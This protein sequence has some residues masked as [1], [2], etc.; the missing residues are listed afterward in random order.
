MACDD[1]NQCTFNDVCNSSSS[2][3]GTLALGTLCDDGN[4]CTFD[5]VCTNYYGCVGSRADDGTPCYRGNP[6]SPADYC[7]DGQCYDGPFRDCD[8]RDRCDGIDYCDFDSGECVPYPVPLCD[9]HNECTG[10]TCDPIAGCVFTPIDAPCDDGDAC[11]VGDRCVNRACLWGPVDDCDDANPC[12]DDSCDVA[13]G[14]LH[15]PHAGACDDGNACTALDTCQAGV[16][17]GTNPVVCGTPALCQAA[18]VCEPT[19]GVCHFGNAPDGTTCSDGELCTTG[20]TCQAGVCT[21]AANGPTEPNPRTN[22]YYKRLCHGPHS[23]DQLTS[24]DGICVAGI[25]RTFAGI[26]TVADLCAMLEPSHPN[27]DPCDRSEDDLIVLALNICRAR[28]CTAQSIDSQCGGNGTV[29]QSL[30]ESDA[31]LNDASRSAATCAHAKCLDEEINT[32]RA[33]ELNSLTLRREG[34]GVRLSWNP[35]YL[36]DGSGHPSKYNVW[37]RQQGSLAAFTKISMRCRR[38]GP[39]NTK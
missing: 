39:S 24:A 20:E 19:T 12:T 32:G 15:V 23:G 13:I 31:I 6:C 4:D 16:C 35:P 14:C 22:G 17:V 26:S 33:L 34:S 37:R 18:G 2:C 36:D 9:D 3:R 28:V 27:Y 5:D 21:P 11:T 30:A 10:D 8:D 29:G 25:T 1:R 7:H 38:A